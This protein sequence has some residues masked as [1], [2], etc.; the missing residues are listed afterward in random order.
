MSA[1][2]CKVD[3][4]RAVWIG[5]KINVEHRFSAVASDDDAIGNLWFKSKDQK[6][7]LRTLDVSV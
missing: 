4:H 2:Q 7:Q 3:E 6:A 1:T 5:R